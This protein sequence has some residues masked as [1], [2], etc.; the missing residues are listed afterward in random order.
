MNNFLNKKEQS[1]L[2]KGMADKINEGIEKHFDETGDDI[3]EF[4]IGMMDF[5][6][7][8]PN[9]EANDE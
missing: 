4:S 1:K 3:L 9:N 8:N 7:S 2:F 6:I 5:K